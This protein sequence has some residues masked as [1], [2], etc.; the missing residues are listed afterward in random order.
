MKEACVG[1]DQPFIADDQAAEM[2]KPREGAFHDPPPSIAPQ[3]PAILMRGVLVVAASRDNRLNTPTGQPS[4]Q[5]MA[6]IASI[7][8][9]SR[10]SLSLAD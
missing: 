5:R 8:D 2:A 7:R 10:R 9:Q 3:L 1:R 4:P 6:L